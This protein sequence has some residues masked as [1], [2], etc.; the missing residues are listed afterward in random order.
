VVE[1]EYASS[2]NEHV[3]NIGFQRPTDAEKFVPSQS[4]QINLFPFRAFGMQKAQS[5][6]IIRNDLVI[7]RHRIRASQLMKLINKGARSCLYLC[8]PSGRIIRRVNSVQ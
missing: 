3:S 4:K 1:R 2:A 5:T 8:H 6:G 7:L